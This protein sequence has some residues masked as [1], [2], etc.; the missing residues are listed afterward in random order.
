MAKGGGSRG[1][2][3][4]KEESKAERFKRVV[5]PRVG[6]A[7]K[8]I[9]VIGYCAGSTYEYTPKQVDAIILALNKATL[10]LIDKFAAKSDKQDSF[11]FEE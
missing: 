4:P 9:A 10:T 3:A 11:S 1:Q 7:I 6:K 5:S 8:A 2:S